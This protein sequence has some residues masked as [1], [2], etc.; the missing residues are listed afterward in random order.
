MRV[1]HTHT[2][3]I[4][5]GHVVMPMTI[6]EAAARKDPE[7]SRG[8]E[9]EREVL[10]HSDNRITFIPYFSKMFITLKVN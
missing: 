4:L 10:V 8:S 1:C 3:P 2:K 5:T 7:I 9:R 6:V